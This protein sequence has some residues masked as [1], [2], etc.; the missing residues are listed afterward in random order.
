MITQQRKLQGSNI[1]MTEKIT[2]QR[3]L[4]KW[5]IEQNKYVRENQTQDI[6]IMWPEKIINAAK[7]NQTHK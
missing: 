5:S 2:Q 6:N 4:R 3:N 1:N 7:E